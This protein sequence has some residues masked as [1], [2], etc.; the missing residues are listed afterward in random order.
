M[1][2]DSGAISITVFLRQGIDYNARSSPHGLVM[3]SNLQQPASVCILRLSALGD[4][5]HVLP[6]V[7]ALRERWPGIRITWVCGKLEYKLLQHIESIEFVI[8]DKRGG[9]GAY[10]DL[11][12]ALSNQTFDVLLHMQVAARANIASLCIKAK[13]RIGWDR[14]NS[15][16]LHHLFV[17]EMIE[18]RA[19]RHQVDAFLAFAARL[20]ASSSEPAW[21]IPVQADAVQWVNDRIDTA[22]KV[23]L[24]SPCSSHALRN[25]T[26]ERYAQTAD[27]AISRGMRVVIC[28]GPSELEKTTGARIEASMQGQAINLV[29]E[30][31]LQQLLALLQRADVVLSPDSGP[32]HMA[33]A[34]GTPVIGLYACTNPKR[35]GPY[36]SLQHCTNRFGEAVEKFAAGKKLRWNS[37][38]EQPGVMELITVEEV[39]AKLDNL[40]AE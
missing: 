25:W 31:T 36:N 5:T 16:D 32:A 33:N 8:F 24:I 18:S 19:E 6:V 37:K 29:G 4:V 39:I 1:D 14:A 7:N 15:R 34:V 9:I 11:R 20:D 13:R 22:D 30:D 27:Y 3:T 2:P 21:N 26:V 35:S 28:G 23:F 40:L 12:K 10:L 17:N 38:I